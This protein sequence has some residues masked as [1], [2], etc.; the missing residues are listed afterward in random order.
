MS[1]NFTYEADEL[2]T[3]AIMS[4]TPI[5]IV[6]G[7]D[8]VPFYEEII[9]SLER[10][11]EVYASENLLISEGV[12]G[13]NGVKKCLKKIN[14]NADGVDVKKYILGIIDKDVGD[15]R[16]DLDTNMEGLFVLKYYSIESHFINKHNVKYL[17]HQ[18]T[19]ASSSLLDSLNLE[20]ALFEDIK[21]DLSDLY[22][23]S[24]DALKSECDIS[25]SSKYIY[26][27]SI[28]QILKDN[29]EEKL[30]EKIAELDEFA[31]T[32]GISNTFENL[33]FIV[34][35]KW[36]MEFF[37][38]KMKTIL[39]NLNT[40]CSQQKLCQFCK[41]DKSDQCSFKLL[42]HYDIKRAKGML[43]KN[44]NIPEISYIKDEIAKLSA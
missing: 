40:K 14:D 1:V 15:F 21:N 31:S 35:G 39:D 20:E 10:E 19:N 2:L 26:S 6:E 36:M 24:L 25:Y 3:E 41:T 28:I 11:M 7:S 37:I 17:I 42:F 23:V 13:C 18:I 9:K 27:N 33:L 30:S 43:F 4:S 44:I 34:K 16:G 29:Y 5:I 12:S 38:L 22:Y 8:D 32:L